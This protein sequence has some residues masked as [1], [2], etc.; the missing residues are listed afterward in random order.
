M[1]GTGY[2][3]DWRFQQWHVDT[4]EPTVGV[5]PSMSQKCRL[6]IAKVADKDRIAQ[7]INEVNISSGL[8]DDP[9]RWRSHIW[10]EHVVQALT[11][12]WGIAPSYPVRTWSFINPQ[13]HN[14]AQVV[15]AG[16]HDL[17]GPRHM[18]TRDLM[19]G[20]DTFT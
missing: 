5:N 11:G 7:I 6:R 2:S 12:D 17:S 13:A 10:A 18:A 8:N 16:N 14:L 15:D 9:Q 19:V 1:I 4:T 3:L 20:G